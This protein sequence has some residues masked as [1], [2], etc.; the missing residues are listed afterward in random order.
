MISFRLRISMLAL[1]I[2]TC[3][4]EDITLQRNTVMRVDRS[5]VSLKAGT[6]VEVLERG[7]KI[8]S[9]R[10]KGQTGTIPTSSLTAAAGSPVA[11]APATAKPAAPAA[12]AAPA[13]KPLVVDNPQ[14]TYGN[15]VKKAQT[16]A[17]KHNDNLV[18]PASDATGDIPSK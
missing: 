4:A 15:L 5:L 6:I 7:D 11:S 13:P 12:S 16:N 18:K 17:A 1:S 10:Y 14:S 2:G 9:I 8:V 3:M